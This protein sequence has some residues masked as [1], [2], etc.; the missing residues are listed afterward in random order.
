LLPV[1]EEK[2]ASVNIGILKSKDIARLIAEKFPQKELSQIQRDV[3][4]KLAVNFL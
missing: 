4:V 1:A 3:D 2:S